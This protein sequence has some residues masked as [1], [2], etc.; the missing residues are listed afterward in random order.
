MFHIKI[1]IAQKN[2]NDN[3][4]EKTNCFKEQGHF[5]GFSKNQ[6]GIISK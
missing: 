4:Y 3:Y 5:V 1:Q 6:L 2:D